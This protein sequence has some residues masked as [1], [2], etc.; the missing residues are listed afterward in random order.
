MPGEADRLAGIGHFRFEEGIEAL[1]DFVGHRVKHIAALGR[2]SATRA[3]SVPS[4]GVRL[5]NTRPLRA[6][7]NSPPTKLQM[8]LSVAFDLL[9]ISSIGSPWAE[10]SLAARRGIALI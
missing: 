4:T 7:A 1:V 2:P 10:A 8:S 9:G 6:G 5:S 3:I